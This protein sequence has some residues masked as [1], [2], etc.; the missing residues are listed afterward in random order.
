MHDWLHTYLAFRK[1]S[2]S[3]KHH[4]FAGCY[5][6][7]VYYI[8]IYLFWSDAERFHKSTQCHPLDQDTDNLGLQSKTY[9]I[10]LLS[11]VSMNSPGMP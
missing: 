3:S 5:Q 1:H 4:N 2:S 9:C 10:A 8:L 7:M 11:L 6:G